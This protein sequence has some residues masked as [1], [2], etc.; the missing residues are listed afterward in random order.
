MVS[1]NVI[2]NSRSSLAGGLVNSDLEYNFDFTRWEQGKYEMSFTYV[3]EVNN[4]QCDKI[5][6]VFCN[7]V[8]NKN[9]TTS[10]IN[11]AHTTLNLGT[12][13][14]GGTTAK[15]YL[16]AGR[17][18]N[19]ATELGGRPSNNTIKV[20]IRDNANALYTDSVAADVG[21]YILTLKFKKIE[22]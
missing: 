15:Q 14:V 13:S 21:E 16:Y 1:Y 12:L 9:Y 5:A 2:L 17:D 22:D 4:L 6:S 3:G 20:Q 11:N 7:L 10:D 19:F 8:E 18:D